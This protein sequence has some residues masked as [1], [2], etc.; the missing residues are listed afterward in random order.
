MSK[1]VLSSS[2]ASELPLWPSV[3]SEAD[4]FSQG[5]KKRQHGTDA[6][7]SHI[8]AARTVAGIVRTSLVS[9]DICCNYREKIG[10]DHA[11]GPAGWTKS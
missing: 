6:V 5:K 2:F 10:T 4:V 3:F 9:F 1:V 8:L 11:R 7:K